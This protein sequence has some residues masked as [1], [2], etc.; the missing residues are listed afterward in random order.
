MKRTFGSI[1]AATLV[2]VGCEGM[3]KHHVALSDVPGP[4]R[5]IIE[6]E[7]MGGTI[8]EVERETRNGRTQ[9]EAEVMLNGK[10]KEV[11]VD[12]AGNLISSH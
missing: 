11:K 5:A 3:G 8:Q 12:D 10:K 1:A 4:A 7:A 6:R 9:Y 2:L